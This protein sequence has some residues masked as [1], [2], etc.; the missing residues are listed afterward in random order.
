MMKYEIDEKILK[1]T[2]DCKRKFKCL[3]SEDH[4]YCRVKDCVEG[5]VHFI[6]CLYEAPCEYKMVFGHSLVCNCPTRKEIYNRYRK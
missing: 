3:E 5:K 1:E 2:T 6:E 4:I